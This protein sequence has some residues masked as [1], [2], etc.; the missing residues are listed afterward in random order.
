MQVITVCSR[1]MGIA[2]PGQNEVATFASGC[3][4]GT[5]HIFLK[6]FPPAENKGIISTRVGYTGGKA[7]DPSYRQVC[8]GDTEPAEAVRIEYDL[9]I[10]KYEDLVGEFSPR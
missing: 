9:T 4:W 6:K 8:S 5:E 10:L 3:F 1:L 7:T 2:Q